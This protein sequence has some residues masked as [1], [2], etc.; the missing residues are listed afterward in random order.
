MSDNLLDTQP[1]GSIKLPSALQTARAQFM[2]AYD[3]FTKDPDAATRQAFEVTRA[4]VRRVEREIR[5]ATWSLYIVLCDKMKK[6][7][8]R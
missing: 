6:P 5:D 1:T 2:E 3:L 8:R 4:E 7:T